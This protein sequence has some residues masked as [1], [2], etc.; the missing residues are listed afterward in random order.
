MTAAI[1]DSAA[2]YLADVPLEKGIGLKNTKITD[3]GLS[4]L[5]KMQTIKSVGLEG[6]FSDKAI[7][8][9]EGLKQLRDVS[10]VN[11]HVSEAGF[12]RLRDSLPLTRIL[13][14]GRRVF[15]K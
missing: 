11:T 6:P 5:R 13:C 1:G 8:H 9:L 3:D 15:S 4:F 2:S 7:V 14:D 12:A 10:F